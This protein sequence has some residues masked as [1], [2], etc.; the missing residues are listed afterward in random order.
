MIKRFLRI[1]LL[2]FALLGLFLSC[3]LSRERQQGSTKVYKVI[4]RV[5]AEGPQ[6]LWMQAGKDLSSAEL[7]QLRSMIAA[8]IGKLSNHKLVS[9]EDKDDDLGLVV[10]AEKLQSGRE[11]YFLLSSALTIAKA[12][13]TD[14]FVTHDVVAA[15][16]LSLEA[17]AVV[18][19]LM[20]VEVRGI[21]GLR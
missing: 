10:V 11:T 13:G 15:A 4:L 12:D 7:L 20:S 14:L 1:I 18:G 9:S 6:G 8:E 17:K 19:C 2:A 3:T 5:E 21:L 16:S